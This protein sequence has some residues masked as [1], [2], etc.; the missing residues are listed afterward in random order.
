MGTPS[1]FRA[2]RRAIVAALLSG[3]FDHEFRVDI[4]TKNL[5]STGRVSVQ[6]LVAALRRCSGRDY[7][8][9]PHHAKAV[10]TVHAI[11]TRP[12]YVKFY[13]VDPETWFISVHE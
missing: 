8:C 4:D 2:V 1:G 9:S 3:Y 6:E 5:L 12:W 7:S 13:F 10:L 11:K